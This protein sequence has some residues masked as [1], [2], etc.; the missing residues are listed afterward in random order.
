[1][2]IWLVYIAH[3]SI[4]LRKQGTAGILSMFQAFLSCL[5]LRMKSNSCVLLWDS[6]YLP[7]VFVP[8]IQNRW[9]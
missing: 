6:N 2:F 3:H 5:P 9:Y 4:Y 8:P 7:E 1:M